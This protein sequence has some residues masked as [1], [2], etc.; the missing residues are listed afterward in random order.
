MAA[1]QDTVDAIAFVLGT[2]TSPAPIKV[3]TY[4]PLAEGMKLPAAV[5]QPPDITRVGVDGAES[6]LGTEDWS[7]NVPVLI[8]V[9]AG[10]A[11]NA[12]AT[13]V[14]YVESFIGAIDANP[15]L[16]AGSGDIAVDA[17]VVS[18]TP[19]WTQD[20]AVP[21]FAYECN[22]QVLRFI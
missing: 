15:G 14:E 18:A 6:Q 7:F 22:V 21:A 19:G 11:R 10:E 2:I 17:K 5:V 12:Q 9:V 8:Y 20:T 13:G 1:V 4:D 3:Y 16:N